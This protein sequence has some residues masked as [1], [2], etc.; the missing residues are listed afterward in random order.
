MCSVYLL[1]VWFFVCGWVCTDVPAYEVYDAR[2]SC[3]DEY[4][5]HSTKNGVI[6]VDWWQYNGFVFAKVSKL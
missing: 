4:G 1:Y 6:T 5:I 3:Q 2:E